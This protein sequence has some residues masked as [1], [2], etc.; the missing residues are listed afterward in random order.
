MH[1]LLGKLLPSMLE[2]IGT[3][4]CFEV[5]PSSCNIIILGFLEHVMVMGKANYARKAPSLN[6]G[7]ILCL[8]YFELGGSVDNQ[9]C[10]GFYR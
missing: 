1:A 9:H 8:P 10:V 3:S 6:R 4:L 7:E 2:K 5:L